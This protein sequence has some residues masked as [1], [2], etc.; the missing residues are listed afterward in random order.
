L[1]IIPAK[2]FEVILAVPPYIVNNPDSKNNGFGDWQFLVKYRI[3]AGNEEHRNYIL[4]AFYQMTLPTGQYQQSALSPVITPT[5][6][7]GKGFGNFDVQGTLS[8]C[9]PT[10]KVG[11]IGH[12]LPW[13]NNVS[14]PRIQE[15]LAGTGVN[16]TT[17]TAGTAILFRPA[18]PAKHCY[19]S[20]RVSCSADFA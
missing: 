14:V 2:N 17:F 8:Y 19:I 7:Y 4:T 5:I 12:T 16:F 1:E 18:V 15:I 20:R 6:A 11:V 9:L 3:A 13:N 10:G